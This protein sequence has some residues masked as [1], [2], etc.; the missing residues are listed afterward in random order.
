MKERNGFGLLMKYPEAGKVKTRLARDIGFRAAAA[1]YRLLAERVLRNTR[2]RREDYERTIFYSPV[3]MR[4]Q[5]ETWIPDGPLIPQRGRDIGERMNNALNSLF[6]SGA[7]RAAIA[8]ADIPDLN[9]DIIKQVFAELDHVDVVI[10]PADDGGY[11]LLGVRSTQYDIFQGI[12]WSTDRVF[13]ET[14]SVIE[15]LGLR[16]KTVITLSDVDTLESLLKIKNR[17]VS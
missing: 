9:A 16:Y 11:Y 4:A 6:D 15:K 7:T 8:G 17:F 12:S 2:A 3:H 13:Q 14:V 10:G 1:A 5:F